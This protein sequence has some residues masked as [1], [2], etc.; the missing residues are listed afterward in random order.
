MSWITGWGLTPFGRLEGVDTLGLMSQGAARA[1]AQADLTRADVDGLICG[2]S[3]ALPHLMLS[4]VFAEHF[5]LAP[6]YAHSLQ[7]GG[8]TGAAMVM[9]AHLLVESGA[10]RNILVVAGENRLSGPGRDSAISTLAQVGH[11]EH[12]VPLGPTVPSYYALVASAYMH[13]FG[14]SE[15]DMATLAVLMRGNAGRHPGAHLR[16]P[17]TVDDVLASRAISTPLKLLDCCPVSDGGG[18]VVVSRDPRAGSRI[19]IRGGG[20]AHLHQHVSQLR[21]IEAVGADLALRRAEAASGLSRREVDYLGVYDSF[22][23]TLLLLLEEMGF[24]ERGG[25]ADRVRR[26]DFSPDGPLPLNT[27]GGLL[28][29]GHCGVAGAL[30]HVVEICAQMSESAGERQIAPPHL[31]LIHSDGGVLSSH[32]SLFVARE[33]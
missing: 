26:G 2:Y 14:V 33:D 25:A 28:S 24:A 18:A 16:D 17:I 3:T 11:P 21:S 23:I 32:V 22:S 27:H 19:R 7:L 15:A 6:A 31:A 1:L 13:R 20:Q 12:E 5:G 10:A 8:A 4:T 29:Y 30:A 9:L